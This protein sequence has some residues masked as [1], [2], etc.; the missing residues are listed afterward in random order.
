VG[1]LYPLELLLLAP[2]VLVRPDAV[3]PGRQPPAL[4]PLRPVVA[5]TL[6]DVRVHT[7][8]QHEHLL[9]L[10]RAHVGAG[11]V[12]LPE[13]GGGGGGEEEEQGGE[14]QP[15]PG[16][17]PSAHFLQQ[18]N[19][20]E[21]HLAS[22]VGKKDGGQKSLKSNLSSGFLCAKRSGRKSRK[23]KF[24]TYGAHL[25]HGDEGDENDPEN[26]IAYEEVA[27]YYPRAERKRP[28][29]LI[30]PS[31]IGRHELRHKL[32]QDVDRFQ[33]AIPHTSRPKRADEIDGQDYHFISRLQFE[34][35]IVARKF[36]EHGEYEKAYYGTSLESIRNVVFSEKICVLNLH[37]QCLK[38]LK[39]SNLMPYVVFVAPGNLDKLKKFKMTQQNEQLSD[40]QLKDIIEKARHI[41][42]MYGHFFDM[43]IQMTDIDK[44][45]RELLSA[46]NVLE[47]EPQWVPAAWLSSTNMD[48]Y[49]SSM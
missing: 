37:P 24:H 5:G 43:F 42:S 4:V 21:Q 15:L 16:L 31:N 8:L 35:D 2:G 18:L 29:V 1:A 49:P 45:Y 11:D 27:L 36:V 47:R 12:V 46:I 19:G 9:V 3:G 38:M 33:Q 40:D 7:A 39:S 20:I 6:P 44:A 25:G 26:I 28:V 34:Q 22:E 48:M 23:N 30:G 10:R 14:D 13:E 17:I 32:M 41:E